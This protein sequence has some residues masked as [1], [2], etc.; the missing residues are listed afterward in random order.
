MRAL[1]GNEDVARR[2]GPGIA[3]DSGNGGS[4]LAGTRTVRPQQAASDER[5]MQIAPG[6]GRA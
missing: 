6:H 5:V 3:C 4:R 2:D 1:E